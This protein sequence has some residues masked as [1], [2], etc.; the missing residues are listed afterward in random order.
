MAASAVN[1]FGLGARPAELEQARDARAWLH[2]QL[3]AKPDLRACLKSF[4]YPQSYED[5]KKLSQ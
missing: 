5:E 2:A 1:R 3:R 4:S